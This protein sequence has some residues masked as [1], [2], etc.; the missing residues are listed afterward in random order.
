MKCYQASNRRDKSGA[1]S[2]FDPDGVWVQSYGASRE[3]AR[4]RAKEFQR[5]ME[6]GET[7]LDIMRSERPFE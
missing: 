1:W 4:K 3:T 2:V 5:R 7:M 6:M